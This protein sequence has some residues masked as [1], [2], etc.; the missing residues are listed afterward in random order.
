VL[1]MSGTFNVSREIWDHEMFRGGV[2]TEREAFLW[3]ISEAA[4]KPRAKRFRNGSVSLDRGQ[5]CASVRFMADAWGWSKSRVSRFL[6]MLKKRDM[7]GAQ[8]GTG[9]LVVTI[10]N[11]AK[12]QHTQRKPG[13]LAGHEPGHSRDTRG[14]NENKGIREEEEG[15]GG[16]AGARDDI[17]FSPDEPNDPDLLDRVIEA[18]QIDIQRDRSPQRWFGSEPRHT[19]EQWQGL[20]LSDDEIIETVSEVMASKL[21]GPPA[22]LSYFNTA[23]QRRAGRK[24]RPDLM[25]ID[26][27][28]TNDGKSARERR[29]EA[30]L[31]SALAFARDLDRAAAGG[32]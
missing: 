13:T 31:E 25:P 2:F 21:D 27:G 22:K 20:G 5:L 17:P 11:Y 12:Y 19:I 28:K 29:A 6:D 1:A 24:A 4:W 30:R 7:I 3:L 14:T 18:A 9:I 32:P 15:G 16:S 8:S 26:G 23:M 10:C